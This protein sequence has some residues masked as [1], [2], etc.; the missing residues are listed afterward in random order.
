MIGTFDKYLNEKTDLVSNYV[1]YVFNKGI[2]QAENKFQFSWQYISQFKKGGQITLKSS[3]EVVFQFVQGV[4]VISVPSSKS[5][6]VIIDDI[7]KFAESNEYK[8]LTKAVSFKIDSKI[9][10]NLK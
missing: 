3:P 4:P 6:N 2:F 7:A 9:L 10:G 5:R 8:A 1:N